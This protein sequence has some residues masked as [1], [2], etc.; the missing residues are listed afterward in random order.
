MSAAD[1]E[2]RWIVL[3]DS[4]HYALA[5]ECVFDGGGA[6]RVRP[7]SGTPGAWRCAREGQ[8][9]LPARC[10]RAMIRREGIGMSDEQKARLTETVRGA[11]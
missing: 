11:G 9:I 3:L 2:R 4:I 7:R 8:G 6:P 1:E 5:A 10:D